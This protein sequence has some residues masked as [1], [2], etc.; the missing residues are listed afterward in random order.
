MSPLITLTTLT[1]PRNGSP[2]TVPVRPMEARDPSG[3][4][5]RCDSHAYAGGSAHL[6]GGSSRMDRG[7]LR[8]Y[9]WLLSRRSVPGDRH[10]GRALAAAIITTDTPWGEKSTVAFTAG[11]SPPRSSP[12]TGGE[13]LP[14]CMHALHSAGRSTVAVSLDSNNAAAWPLPSGGFADSPTAATGTATDETPRAAGPLPPGTDQQQPE[15][16]APIMTQLKPTL[17][18]TV[19]NAAAIETELA[20]AVEAVRQA[21]LAERRCGILITRPGQESTRSASARTCRSA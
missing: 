16:D 13:R 1:G 12:G 18:V 21:A 7:P 10:P 6:Q 3:T 15:Q 20:A 19:S 4:R 8:R 17:E 11:A 2:A 9:A 5:A 14:R